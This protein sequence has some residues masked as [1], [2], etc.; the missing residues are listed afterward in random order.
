MDG[1]V[2]ELEERLARISADHPESPDQVDAMIDLAEALVTGDDPQRMMELVGEAEELSR[3]IGYGRGSAY[4]LL[5]NSVSCCFIAQHE[6]GLKKTSESRELFK[7]LKDEFGVAKTELMDGNLLRSIGSFDQALPHF[8]RAVD[9]FRTHGHELWEGMAH[10]DLGLLF[11]E[12]GD[13]KKARENF[14]AAVK[15]CGETNN[16]VQGRALNGIGTAYRNTGDKDAAV[17]YYHKSL[18]I[19]R[20]INNQMG[21]ARALD[22]IGSVHREL[23]DPTLALEF[24]GRSAEIRRALGVRRALCT[25]LLNVARAHLDR[26]DAGNALPVIEEALALAEEAK[27]RSQVFAAHSL[28]SRVYEGDGDYARALKHFQEFERIKDEVFNQQT[29]DRIQHLQIGFAVERA[30]KEAEIA[31]LKNVELRKKNDNL[32]AL[33]H[34]LQDT[35]GQLVQ[36]EK[37]AAVGKL[38]AGLLHE[39]NTPMGASNTAMDVCERCIDKISTLQ[40]SLPES[41]VQNIKEL[42]ALLQRIQDSHAIARDAH[43]RISKILN[44]LKS[45]IRLDDSERQIVDLHDGI[46]ATLALLEHE[47]KDRIQVVRRYGKL[48]GVVC[49]PGE[50]NQVFMT[51]LSNAVESIPGTGT[52]AIKTTTVNGAARV[53]ISDTGIGIEPARVKHLFDTGFS[54]KGR[55]VKAGMGLLSGLNIV[56]KHGGHID[57]DSTPGVGSTFT[58]VLPLGSP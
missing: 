44:S 18:S 5:Y 20:E 33:L 17:D 24:H 3:R 34:E 38:V 31:H 16:W 13:N 4:S 19:F 46:E 10:Y 41:D 23:G 42:R 2:K 12:I 6:E 51:I 7:G 58:I 25:S 29:T 36:A 15:L 53:E 32:E 54:T 28:L 56:Q 1:R 55:R 43:A 45:F 57:V 47:C 11:L 39:M 26:K 14:E 21:E 52:I 37:L 48:P 9:Y 50:I 30:E 8:H 49:Y 35:Q 22:D 27:S 40:G